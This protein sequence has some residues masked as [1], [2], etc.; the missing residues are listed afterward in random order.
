MS[1]LVFF[2]VMAVFSGSDATNGTLFVVTAEMFQLSTVSVDLNI[3]NYFLD[4]GFFHYFLYLFDDVDG[5]LDNLFYPWVSSVLLETSYFGIGGK[6]L[7]KIA[8]Y[9]AAHN[10]SA[11]GP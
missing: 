6:L 2:R 9:I 11:H 7:R 5:Y 3:F 1:L 4:D 10:R 8:V